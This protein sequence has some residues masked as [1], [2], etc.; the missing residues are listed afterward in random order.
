[1][2]QLGLH[3]GDVAGE[4]DVDDF[5]TQI[6]ADERV[7]GGFLRRVDGIHVLAAAVGD[8]GDAQELQVPGKSGLGDVHAL[9]LQ[10]LEKLLLAVNLLGVQD[11]MDQ[12]A[13]RF[14]AFQIRPPVE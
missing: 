1:V 13:P 8:A 5:P 3:D 11:A 9:L 10:T 14:L 7:L 4:L 12:A 6:V 2:S